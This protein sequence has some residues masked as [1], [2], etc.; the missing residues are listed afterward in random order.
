MSTPLPKLQFSLWDLIL[1]MYV[2]FMLHDRHE[3]TMHLNITVPCMLPQ[4][5]CCMHVIGTPENTEYRITEQRN[6]GISG[7]RLNR[8]IIQTRCL[9]N[10]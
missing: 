3:Y 8:F 10:A 1:Y 2:T 9:I 4:H 7:F 6:N 5:L